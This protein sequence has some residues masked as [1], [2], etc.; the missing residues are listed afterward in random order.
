VTN[1][2]FGVKVTTG[3][4]D[5]S[6]KLKVYTEHR[7]T[8]QGD[9]RL[10]EIEPAQAGVGSPAFSARWDHTANTVDVD[11]IRHRTLHQN[12]QGHHTIMVSPGVSEIDI[13]VG[14]QHIFKGSVTLGTELGL[15]IGDSL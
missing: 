14:G 15:R 6:Y 12:F 7:S 10:F 11:L 1:G 4:V 8:P 13:R 2:A 9:L 5:A 3:H